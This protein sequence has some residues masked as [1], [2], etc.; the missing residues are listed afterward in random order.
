MSEDPMI[1]VYAK[2]EQKQTLKKLMC[3]FKKLCQEYAEHKQQRKKEQEKRKNAD[4]DYQNK[5]AALKQKRSDEQEKRE[6]EETLKNEQQNTHDK[7]CESDINCP[8][9][10]ANKKDHVLIPCGHIFCGICI[11]Q[12]NHA[13]PLCRQKFTTTIKC[14]I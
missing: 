2:I 13:C 7:D 4:I 6:H 5:L 14:F 10:M 8:I 11:D 3:P 1:A 12:F 9:C